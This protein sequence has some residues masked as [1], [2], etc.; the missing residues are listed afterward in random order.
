MAFTNHQS[1]CSLGWSWWLVVEWCER[2]ILLAGWWLVL[3]RCK[4][5]TVELEAGGAAEHSEC[6]TSFV[7]IRHTCTYGTEIIVL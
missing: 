7:R 3:E 5:K 4:K 2:K 6:V 1:L